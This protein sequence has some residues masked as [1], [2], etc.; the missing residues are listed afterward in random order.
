MEPLEYL[1]L[2]MNL[3]GKGYRQNGLITRLSPNSDDFP[4]VLLAQTSNG[5]TVTYLSDTL[6]FE[7]RRELATCA[8]KLEFPRVEVLLEPIRSYG[9]QPKVGYY[10]TYVF[11]EQYAKVEPTVAKCFPKDDP[12]VKDFGFSGFANMV[13]AIEES[14][15]ILSAC[16]SVR[17]NSK[18]AEAWVFTTSEHRRKGLAQRVVAAWAKGMLDEGIIP[19]YSHKIDN[20]ASAKLANRLGLISVFEKI[21]IEGDVFTNYRGPL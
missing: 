18:C 3:E 8:S 21:S 20:L 5:Q 17:Q 7:L 4:L 6:P 19:F 14:G 10:K 13:Y 12:K 9:I 11:P 16:V 15:K 2:Q 1:H